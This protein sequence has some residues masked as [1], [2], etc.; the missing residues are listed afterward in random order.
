MNR[1]LK[2]AAGVNDIQADLGFNNLPGH[3]LHARLPTG[4]C[5]CYAAGPGHH[6]HHSHST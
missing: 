3:C 4:T 1:T 2:L 5:C 6:Q